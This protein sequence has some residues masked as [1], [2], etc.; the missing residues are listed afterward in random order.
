MVQVL[1]LWIPQLQMH[2]LAADAASA[3]LVSRSATKASFL[4]PKP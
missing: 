1:P 3:M 4:N 2:M